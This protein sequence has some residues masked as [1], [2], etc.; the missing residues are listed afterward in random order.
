MLGGENDKDSIL[1]KVC[2][3]VQMIEHELEF[4]GNSEHNNIIKNTHFFL[5]YAGKNNVPSKRPVT[6]P[7]KTTVRHD[8]R[9]KQKS[10]GRME[11]ASDKKENE[12]YEKF[13]KAVSDLGLKKCREE[14]FPGKA[15]PRAKKVKGEGKIRE[16]SVFSAC[17]FAKIVDAGFFNPWRWGAYHTYF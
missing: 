11:Y 17:D 12:I 4:G 9:G 6:M 7:E 8:F 16:F 10:A 5:V 1:R 2:D 15:L 3:S 14:D 13:G